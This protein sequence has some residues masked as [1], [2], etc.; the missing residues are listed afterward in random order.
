[1]WNTD[2]KLPHAINKTCHKYVDTNNNVPTVF[3]VY[4]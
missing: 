2:W 1:M 4:V 3:T